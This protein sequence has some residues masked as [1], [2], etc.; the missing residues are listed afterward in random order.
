MQP[1]PAAP[2]QTVHGVTFPLAKFLR[3][4]SPQSAAAVDGKDAN[5][6]SIKKS[7]E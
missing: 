1:A 4:I 2:I 7:V 5:Q 6:G 3:A